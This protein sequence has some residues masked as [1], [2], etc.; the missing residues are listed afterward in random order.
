VSL[1]TISKSV[2]VLARR[3]WIERWVDKH[4][5]RQTIVRL[6]PKGRRALGD[7]KRRAERH[8]ARKLSP[9]RPAERA[10]LVSALGLVASA[11]VN[12][13]EENVS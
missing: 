7:M 8:L 9:L 2:D 5:R 1:P 4:D 12:N 3:G 11:F 13:A 10:G 6:T